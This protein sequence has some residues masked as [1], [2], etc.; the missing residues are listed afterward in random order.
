MKTLNE[1]V[2]SMQ[3]A[4]ATALGPNRRYDH[5]VALVTYWS[6]AVH[7]R[8][9][10]QD[11][12][13]NLHALFKSTF[14]FDAGEA[15]FSIPAEDPRTAFNRAFESALAEAEPRTQSKETNLFILYY[16]G[17]ASVESDR[18]G[19]ATWDSDDRGTHRIYWSDFQSRLEEVDCDLLLLFDCCH[20]DA[21]MSLKWTFKKRCELLCASGPKDKTVRTSDRS[22]TKLITEILAQ[23]FKHYR[24]CDILK[25]RSK[26]T[27]SQNMHA[28]TIDPSYRLLSKPVQPSILLHVPAG[29]GADNSTMLELRRMPDARALLKVPF[30][31]HEIKTQIEH[32]QQFPKLK[33]LD[34]SEVELY[35]ASEM[36]VHCAYEARDVVAIVSVPLWI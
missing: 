26:L 35:V 3:K 27:S 24:Q 10:L 32:W 18:S 33:P 19:R 28:L 6:D 17:H 31:D 34:A 15:P 29:T 13:T 23:E 30:L 21:M 8:P 2:E 7:D 12:A 16:G 5:V 20:R 11:Q 4:A 14:N 9:Y 1:F 36:V 25:L 22:F